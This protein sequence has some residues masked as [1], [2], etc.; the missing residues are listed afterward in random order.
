MFEFLPANKAATLS[1]IFSIWESCIWVL[2]PARGTLHHNPGFLFYFLSLTVEVNLCWKLQTSGTT[3]T[4]GGCQMLFVAPLYRNLFKNLFRVKYIVSY[5]ANIRLNWCF[6]TQIC[7]STLDLLNIQKIIKPFN[8]QH[9]IFI[10]IAV[11]HICTT[12][13][14]VCHL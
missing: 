12:H 2:A 4:I 9:Q 13:C 8:M 5:L 1:I 3:C 14:S 7:V 6:Y 11:I 10:S